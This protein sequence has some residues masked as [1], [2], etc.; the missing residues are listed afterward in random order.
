M[1][2]V[3]FRKRTTLT[4]LYNDHLLFGMEEEGR[5]AQPM[6]SPRIRN[7]NSSA[8]GHGLRSRGLIPPGLRPGAYRYPAN[9]FALRLHR[10]AI[11]FLL[12]M[13]KADG[14]CNNKGQIEQGAEYTRFHSDVGIIAPPTSFV[15]PLFCF[16]V[17]Y[18]S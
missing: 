2:D 14:R 7:G 12:R 9:R 1:V 16:G 15:N 18:F 6:I 11:V 8:G 17:R 3:G 10:C 5:I 4:T 13:G